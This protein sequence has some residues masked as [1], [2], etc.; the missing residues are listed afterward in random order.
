MYVYVL[1]LERNKYYV[2]KT[3]YS[4]FNYNNRF[5]ST[6]QLWLN[7]YNPIK[8][9]ELIPLNTDVNMIVIKYMT[10]YGIDNVR[11]G[12]FSNFELNIDSINIINKLITNTSNR[13]FNHTNVIFDKLPQKL[14]NPEM[15]NIIPELINEIKNCNCI[16]SYL[17]THKRCITTFLGY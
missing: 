2:G 15:N 16:L 3:Q 13:N 10:I 11:G 17:Y 14:Y 5:I 8:L 1:E 6:S 9:L 12:I 4:N 7:T